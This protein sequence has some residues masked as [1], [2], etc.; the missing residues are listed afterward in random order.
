MGQAPRALLVLLYSILTTTPR[1]YSHFIGEE[2][3]IVRGSFSQSSKTKEQ[4][5]GESRI[6]IVCP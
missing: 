4:V 3:Q 5:S 2:T 1:D 6:Q